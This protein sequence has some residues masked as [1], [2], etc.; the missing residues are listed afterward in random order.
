MPIDP[1]ML[2]DVTDWFAQTGEPRM[3]SHGHTV[4]PF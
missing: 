3:H 4:Q 2:Q 1:V